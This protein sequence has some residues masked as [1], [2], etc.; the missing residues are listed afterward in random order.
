MDIEE[1]LGNP[2]F[3]ILAGVGEMAFVIMLMVLKG[4]GNAEIMPTL[5]KIVTFLVVPVI[6]FI[7]ASMMEN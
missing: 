6:A 7:W 4:M 2:T 1:T 3:L 5:V